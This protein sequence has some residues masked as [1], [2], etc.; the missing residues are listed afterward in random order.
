[1]PIAEERASQAHDQQ[2]MVHFQRHFG[3]TRLFETSVYDNPALGKLTVG[4]YASDHCL[5]AVRVN[6]G[7]S[8][9]AE[10]HF[11]KEVQYAGPAPKAI[12]VTSIASIPVA[13]AVMAAPVST[14]A[15]I[16]GRCVQPHPGDFRWWYGARNG[17]WVQLFRLWPDGCQHY[18]FFN[19]C[20]SAWDV[21][22][23]GGP[24]IYWVA[25]VH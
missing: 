2:D 21:N 11:I 8:A 7:Q 19:T 4:Y 22:P 25:C 10:Y 23:G 1:M 12:H 15:Q 9:G 6:V 17:C 18:Q 5:V 3:E 13:I 24:R 14:P 20:N 16:R